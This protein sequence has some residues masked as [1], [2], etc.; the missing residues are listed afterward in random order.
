MHV[1]A[2]CFDYGGT[3]DAP[4]IHWLERFAALYAQ[5]G[6]ELDWETVRD[7]FDYATDLAYHDPSVPEMNLQPL[8]RFHVARQSERLGLHD[9]QLSKTVEEGFIAAS[10]KALAESYGV[11]EGLRQRY[12]LGVIS[13]FYGNVDRLLEEAGILPLLTV[14]IDSNRAGVRKPDPAI[15]Q[16]AVD[17][18][19][20]APHEILYVGDSFPKDIVGAHGA[21]WRTAW[22]TGSVERACPDPS[23]VDLRIRSL[24]EIEGLIQP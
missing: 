17:A 10:R 19:G 21:G 24:T 9:P 14:V 23:L 13:N 12:Q 20:C 16:L 1:R 7:A 5:A 6:C 18:L 8:V 2:I 22:L 11:L 4:G 15:F 3:L